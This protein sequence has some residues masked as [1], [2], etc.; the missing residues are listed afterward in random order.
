VVV[1]WALGGPV[2]VFEVGVGVGVVA[3]LVLPPHAAPVTTAKKIAAARTLVAPFL[4][5]TIATTL[6]GNSRRMASK[7]Q[8][9]TKERGGRLCRTASHQE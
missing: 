8:T 1:N 7:A 5:K 9:V 2:G 6:A 4:K 3:G